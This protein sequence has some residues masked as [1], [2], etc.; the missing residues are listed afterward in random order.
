MP[1]FIIYFMAI[2][3]LIGMVF[4]IIWEMFHGQISLSLVLLLLLVNFVSR[5]RLELMYALLNVSI[6][7]ILINL[8]GFQLLVMLPVHRN[9]FFPLY[10][11]NK[12]S[13]PKLKF[14]QASNRWKKVL[15]V[16]KPAYN[17]K[18][19]ESLPRK[20]ALENFGEWLIVLSTKVN[21][22]YLSTQQSGVVFCT[23]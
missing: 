8:H 2:L 12:P 13:E 19:K 18:T 17:N 5:F 11:Q 4:I 7:S 14:R 10:K 21:L 22:L 1:H 6:S 3:V 20:L 16:S 23:W 15:E 9:H